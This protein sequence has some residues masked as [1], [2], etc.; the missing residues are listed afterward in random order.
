LHERTVRHS[1]TELPERRILRLPVHVVLDVDVKNSLVPTRVDQTAEP[2]SG[3]E[4]HV[5]CVV[6]VEGRD[7]I[8]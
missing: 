3:I 5:K 7:L 4:M 8:V 1:S 6:V 2:I